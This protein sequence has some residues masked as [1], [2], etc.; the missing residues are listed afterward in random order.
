MIR[1]SASFA[2][3]LAL[4]SGGCDGLFE[5]EGCTL[6]GCVNGAS[7]SVARVGAWAGGEYSLEV[8]LGAQQHSCRFT[9]PLPPAARPNE[10]S[11]AEQR[12]ACTPVLPPQSGPSESVVYR[13]D[14]PA[15]VACPAADAGAGRTCGSEHYRLSI[16]LDDSATDVGLRLSL[17]DTV[18]LDERRTLE[19]QTSYPNGPDCGGPCRFASLSFDVEEP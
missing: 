7:L 5:E 12:L 13:V 1:F 18:L 2:A 19:Y 15:S 16:G 6:V 17:G 8:Q 14:P 10:I 11:L 9:L 4:A 3:A